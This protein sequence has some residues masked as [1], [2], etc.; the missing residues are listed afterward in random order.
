M[1]IPPLKDLTSLSVK[2]AMIFASIFLLIV[3]G[4]GSLLVYFPNALIALDAF[5]ILIIALAI[6]ITLIVPACIVIL[7]QKPPGAMTF[8]QRF[9]W[10]FVSGAAAS[11]VISSVLLVIMYIFNLDI[12]IWLAILLLSSVAISYLTEK[13]Q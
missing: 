5:K 9:K 3:P 6:G 1:N 2:H 4:L 10:A 12:K 7:A 13:V 8:E 11:A